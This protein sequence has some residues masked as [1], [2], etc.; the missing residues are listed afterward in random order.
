MSYIHSNLE[1]LKDIHELLMNKVNK[2]ELNI[3]INDLN[4]ICLKIESTEN[5]VYELQETIKDQNVTLERLYTDVKNLYQKLRPE[6]LKDEKIYKPRLE[7]DTGI[8]VPRINL[9]SKI[10]G[11]NI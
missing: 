2:E 11:N 3:I 9:K 6:D 10:L 8:V 1:R 5:V 4:S 7:I